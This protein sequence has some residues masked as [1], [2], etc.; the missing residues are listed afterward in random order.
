MSTTTRAGPL[1]LDDDG[2]AT[3]TDDDDDDDD[4]DDNDALVLEV[5]G[6]RCRLR[7]VAR[8]L[9]PSIFSR[10]LGPFACCYDG[11]EWW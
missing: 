3:S 9:V 5:V 6:G 11:F 10:G 7:R 1:P 4:D 2:A 8:F